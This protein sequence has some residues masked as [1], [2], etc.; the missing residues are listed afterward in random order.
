MNT[1]KTVILIIVGIIAVAIFV[2][3]TQLL[4]KKAK[5]KAEIN[6]TL[7]KSFAIYFSLLFLSG[8]VIQ[9]KSIGILSEAVDNI[10]KLK[11]LLTLNPKC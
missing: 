4:L 6:G 10:F 3:I 2:L 5:L 7:N 9:I 1:Q 11:I 8:S